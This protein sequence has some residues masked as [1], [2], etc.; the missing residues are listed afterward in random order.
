MKN[1]DYPIKEEPINIVSDIDALYEKQDKERLKEAILLS[2]TEKFRLFTR[3]M[4]IDKMMQ[5]AK[6]THKKIE[7]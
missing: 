2:D 3:L 6:V 5:N 4:R 7:E 1:K